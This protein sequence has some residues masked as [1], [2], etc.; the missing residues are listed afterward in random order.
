MK[1][2][3]IRFSSIGD[4][5][6][7][8][9]VIRCV[10]STYP[11]A[12]VH[13][14]TKKGYASIL[15]SNPYL[16]KVHCFEGDLNATLKTLRAEKFDFV[17]DLHNS[18][19]SR[20]LRLRLRV[21][22]KA[23]PK[24]NW[25][26]WLLVNFKINRLPNIHIVDRYFEAAAP[27]GVKSDN[28]GLDFFIAEKDEFERSWLPESFQDGFIVYAIGGQHNTKKL[29]YLRMIELCDRIGK[30]T[31]LIGGK[32][33]AAIGQ[34]IEDFFSHKADPEYAQ[35]LEDLGKR[36]QV[37]S[38]CGKLSIAQSASVI[39]QSRAVFTHDTGMMHIAA[40]FRKQIYSIW[41]NTVPAFG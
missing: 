36:T 4:I 18:L 12:E 15:E 23:F 25:Q 19:R 34:K 8:T 41:G 14:L 21:K 27:L 17:L 26:K 39:R 2:L 37:L 9:P 38:L 6:L 33:D 5:V 11:D 24:L 16:T 1:I 10:R 3:L 30:P 13:Y 40:A 32:E 28:L 7:T 22:G 31:I 29:P 20:I 35:G